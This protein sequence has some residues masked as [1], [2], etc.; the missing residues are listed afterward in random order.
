MGSFFSRLI[1][2]IY[3][4]NKDEGVVR[5]AHLTFWGSRMDE[6]S[7]KSDFQPFSDSSEQLN[8]AYLH[9]KRYSDD[10]GKPLYITLKYGEIYEI[11]EFESIFG[12][13]PG[14]TYKRQPS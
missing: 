9:V 6:V 1:G 12:T 11:K 14:V 2:I 4:S 8:D 10:S 7:L 3:V 13:L 5:V